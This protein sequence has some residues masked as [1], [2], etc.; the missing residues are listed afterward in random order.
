MKKEKEK[1]RTFNVA[2]FNVRGL[3]EEYKRGCLSE[4]A[5]R[6]NTDVI[7]IQEAKSEATDCNIGHNKLILF[8]SDSQHYGNGFIVNK[9]WK[10]N[11]HR[12][13]RVSD[14]IAVIQ[15]KTRDQH[16]NFACKKVEGDNLRY[17]I[18]RK[19]SYHSELITKRVRRGFT[20]RKVTDTKMIL[21]RDKKQHKNRMRKQNLRIT[22]AKDRHLITVINVYAPH[23]GIV[24]ETPEALDEFY[25]ELNK[26]YR[27]IQKDGTSSQIFIGGDFN[28]R[29]GSRSEA[30]E[31]IGSYARGTRNENGQ[32]LVD[33]CTLNNLFITNTAFQHPMKHRTT[34]QMS[35]TDETKTKHF[36][37]QIDYILCQTN[38]KQSLINAR[39]YAGTKTFSD[40]RIVKAELHIEPYNLFK[41]KKTTSTKSINVG[42]LH[43]TTTRE[44]YK[45][46]IK[47]SLQES[48]EARR[49]EPT[50]EAW[51]RVANSVVTIAGEVLGHQR[52]KRSRNR[53]F[54]PHVERLSEQQRSTRMRINTCR[55]PARTRELRAE[56]NKIMHAIRKKN[57]ENREREIDELVSEIDKYHD[58]TKMFKATKAL[59][60]NS[61]ENPYVTDSNNKRITNPQEMYN[62]IKEHFNKHFYDPDQNNIEPFVGEPSALTAPITLGETIAAAKKLNNNRAP[63]NDEITAE[64]VKYAPDELHVFITEVLNASLEKHQPVEIG[65]GI[66]VPLQKPGKDKGPVKNLRPVILL[67][68]IRKILSNILLARIKLKYEKYLSP[69]QSAYRSGRSTAD[70]VWAHRW[71]I[72]KAQTKNINL[73]ITGID[74]S[75]AFDTINREELLA[76][77]TNIINEDEMRMARLLLSNTTLDIKLKGAKTS[78]FDSNVGSP[79]GDGISGV[80]FN[81]YLED[82]LRRA[83]AK[84]NSANINIEHS[85]AAISSPKSLPSE[86]TYADDND[87]P[88]ED[89]VQK[90]HVLNTIY[91]VFPERN[92]KVNEDK[93]EHTVVKRG[94]CEE[95]KLWRNVRKLGSLLGDKEDIVKRKLLSSVAMDKYEKVWVRRDRIGLVKRLTLYK[96]IVKT[97]LIYNMCT[98]GLR[99]ADVI[100]LDAFH[101]NQLRRVVGR[102]WPNRIRNVKLYE[103]CNE[104]P[105]SVSIARQRWKLFGHILRGDPNNPAYQAMQYYFEPTNAGGFRGRSRTTLVTTLGSD[106]H[107]AAQLDPTS[108]PVRQLKTLADLITLKTAA[109]ERDSWRNMTTTI[110]KVVEAEAL[111]NSTTDAQLQ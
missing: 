77:L 16:P 25:N 103:Q 5:E 58:H 79:Q 45:T 64:M 29:V 108:V 66:L 75:A 38:R 39:S 43:D 18:T 19:I 88:T 47:N 11:I 34:W 104:E 13:W 107:A 65:N 9:K 48:A 15:F 42:R 53:G 17:N 67:T 111:P 91:S 7:C 82:A 92:L 74:L 44:A 28:G 84:M 3:K 12:T 109:Q 100:A 30:E 62:E 90:E 8:K 60:R 96:A 52:T 2:T 27:T 81:V 85:Y 105:V 37:H 36:Y 73:L 110:V 87:F 35:R 1:R 54:D 32:A 55:D 78:P 40:H 76:I 33:F 80:F 93:T 83:R 101:R 24:S 46:A 50:A 63:G 106:L 6:Y 72:A 56:R 89:N 51:T 69:S 49:E 98:L 99:K 94:N 71:M 14:R 59:N 22:P 26:T 86:M 68:I 10:D 97:V 61:F 4:D 70:I 23:S 21:I 95:E 41:S 102:R 20:C 31:C 57:T